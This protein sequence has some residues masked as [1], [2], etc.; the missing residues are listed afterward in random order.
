[1]T[2]G[3]RLPDRGKVGMACLIFAESAIFTIFV[4]AYLFYGNVALGGVM[5]LAMILNLMLAAAPATTT[6]IRRRRH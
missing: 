2:E 6:P 5:A 3:W 4:V 1:M